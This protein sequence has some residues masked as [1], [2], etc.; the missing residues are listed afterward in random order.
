MIID[1]PEDG[2][3][4]QLNSDWWNKRLEPTIKKGGYI[5]VLSG[6]RGHGKNMNSI[7]GIESFHRKVLNVPI[8]I[9]NDRERNRIVIMAHRK[10]H[11]RIKK[12]IR[13]WK[14]V[15]VEIVIEHAPWEKLK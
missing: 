4:K 7:Y 15:D 13:N 11:K 12:F 2:G 6:G 10:T 1:E 9:D 3:T 8:K 14:P 5:H